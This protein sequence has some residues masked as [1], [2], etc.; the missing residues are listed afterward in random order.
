MGVGEGER[1][2]RCLILNVVRQRDAGKALNGKAA[3]D[4]M[5]IILTE[6]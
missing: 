1:E 2:P 5:T 4:D 3:G 6:C